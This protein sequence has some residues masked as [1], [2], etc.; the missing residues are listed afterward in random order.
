MR[1]SLKREEDQK[2]ITARPVGEQYYV[3]GRGKEHR[4]RYMDNEMVSDN[5]LM[6]APGC[7]R[8]TPTNKER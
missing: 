3:N 5:E 2:P 1:R 8:R 7:F 6:A 4:S